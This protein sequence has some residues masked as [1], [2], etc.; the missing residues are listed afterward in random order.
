V[1]L[2]AGRCGER[3]PR[4]L[5][6]ACPG[7]PRASS[8]SRRRPPGMWEPRRPGT[9]TRSLVLVGD[10]QISADDH[11]CPERHR[12][13][14]EHVE[15]GSQCGAPADPVVGVYQSFEP[16]VVCCS[17]VSVR[18]CP[19]SEDGGDLTA[20][21]GV[22]SFQSAEDA[23]HG[24]VCRGLRPPHGLHRGNTTAH[25]AHGGKTPG[26]AA[27]RPACQV[28]RAPGTHGEAVVALRRRKPVAGRDGQPGRLRFA[29]AT[30]RGEERRNRC[31][32]S[33]C[34][35]NVPLVRPT[36]AWHNGAGVSGWRSYWTCCG[37]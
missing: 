15:E 27:R 33:S 35:Q 32:L 31:P 22:G 4:S 8:G 2:Q 37:R 24:A 5:E 18:V 28:A 6:V 17:R 7:W 34:R 25:P 23:A 29:H 36:G 26:S 11:C 13:A 9:G 30:L 1:A 12:G 14:Q 3:R 20:Q 19:G 21:A 16:G 10:A